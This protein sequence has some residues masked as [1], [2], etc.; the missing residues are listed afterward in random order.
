[1]KWIRK[2]S[3]E[4]LAVS[5]SGV[6]L[7]DRLLVVGCSDP[8]LIAALASKAGLTGRA[9]A[10]DESASLAADAGRIAEREGAL[11]ETAAVPGWQLSYD[12]STFDVAVVRSMLSGTSSDSR[13]PAVREALRVLRP[14]G[15]CVAIE[16]RTRRGLSSLMGGQAGTPNADEVR[17]ALVSA[18]FVAVRTL[19]ERDGMLFVE[20]VKKNR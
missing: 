19:A 4:P 20:G 11:T 14:G 2:P 15:R 17:G 10:V 13:S 3:L 18:G 1:M 7:G 16:G 8:M 6:K 12:T 9:C 5:M